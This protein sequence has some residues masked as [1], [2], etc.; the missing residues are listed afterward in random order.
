MQALA[1]YAAYPLIWLI[2]RLPFSVIYMISDVVY[3]FLYYV[4]KYRRKTVLANLALAFPQ[5]TKSQLQQLSRESTRHFCDLFIE[6]IKS[7]AISKQQ[8][9]KRFICREVGEINAF[10]EANQPVVVMLGHQASYEWTIALDDLLKFK[11]YAVYKPIKNKYFDQFIRNIR[12]KFG[13][14]LVPMKRAYALLKKSQQSNQEVGLFALVADQS[15][16]PSAAQFFTQFF[17]KTTPVFLGGERMAH[18]YAMPV[19]FLRIE[20][21]QRGHYEAYFEKI[22]DNAQKEKDWYVTDTF[23]EKLEEQI[24]QQPAYYLWSH[25]RWKIDPSNV[26]RTVELSPRVPL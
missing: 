14:T 9:K 6:M 12:S 2:A 7:T 22:T 23:F 25:K 19:Y 15:P 18:Q 16:K 1:F 13:T 5:K 20:K 3:F 11:S 21:K 8:L 4:I 10:A 26:R 17:N 24:K